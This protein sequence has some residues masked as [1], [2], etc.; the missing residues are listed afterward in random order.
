MAGL[1]EDVG[2]SGFGAADHVGVRTGVMRD[3]PGLPKDRGYGR[4][5]L[6][7]LAVGLVDELLLPCLL[8][9]LEGG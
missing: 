6:V 3:R 1:A 7:V 4:P 2:G 9:R 5:V 8:D